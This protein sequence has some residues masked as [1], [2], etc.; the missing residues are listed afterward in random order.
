MAS[1]VSVEDTGEA[2]DQVLVV[3]NSLATV[4]SMQQVQ[5]RPILGSSQMFS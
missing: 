3:T 5:S 2:G 1:L 4:I